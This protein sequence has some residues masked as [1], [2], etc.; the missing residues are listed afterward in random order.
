VAALCHRIAILHDSRILECGTPQR[1]FESP[2]H[3]YTRRLV[4]ALPKVSFRSDARSDDAPI[5]DEALVD[6]YGE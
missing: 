2:R 5:P 6:T 1:I 4:A 3:E